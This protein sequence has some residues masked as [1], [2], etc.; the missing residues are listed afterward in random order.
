MN[1]YTIYLSL[2]FVYPATHDNGVE[3]PSW[4]AESHSARQDIPTFG[5]AITLLTKCSP[6]DHILSQVH[7]MH[8]I[9][10][11]L[12]PFSYL[13][14]GLPN[15]LLPLHFLKYVE[16]QDYW[17]QTGNKFTDTFKPAEENDTQCQHLVRWVTTTFNINNVQGD[18]RR[19]CEN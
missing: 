14:L 13:C 9:R 17:R 2:K 18:W 1:Q 16:L 12:T 8:T 5:T 7:L 19:F 4:R 15:G 10:S 3:N 6:P 11:T